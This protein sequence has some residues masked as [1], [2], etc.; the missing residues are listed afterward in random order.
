MSTERREPA[1]DVAG[2]GFGP[3]NLS[4]AIALHETEGTSAR[5]FERQAEFGWHRGMLLEDATMQVSFLKDLV[6]MRD[7]ASDFS[8]VSY[9]T[10]RGRLADFINRK[11]L[12]PL[13][14]EFH[15]YLSWAAA[16]V[17]DLVS[18]G[19]EVVDVRPVEEDGEVHAFDVVARE[20][21]GG[22]TVTRA[23]TV[24][25]GCGL[26]P[27][28]PAGV[29]CSARI[30]H[31]SE[32]LGRVDELAGSDRTPERFVV[33]GAGQSAAEAVDHLYRRFPDAEVCSVFSRFGYSPADDSPFANRVF[34]PEAVDEFHRAP[35]S[36]KRDILDYH[37]NTN[38]SVVDGDLIESLYAA[39]YQE[40]VEGR[41]RLRIMNV[42]RVTEQVE[43]EDG[44]RLHVESST[45]LETEVLDCDAVVYATGYRPTDPVALLGS[46]GGLVALEDDLP[47]VER[48]H[49]LR[50]RVPTAG[51]R[52]FL[53][54][55]DEHAFGL[56]STLLSTVA[57]R[58]GE[59]AGAITGAKGPV[60][61][62]VGD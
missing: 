7:P 20:P 44:V 60:A 62:G 33:V 29:A 53:Q 40:L 36:A 8:F 32:L 59:I 45:T 28:V 35:E 47:V 12:F 55:A 54:G 31:T 5:F 48:D 11:T 23:T 30:W 50:L 1:V 37:R 18:Y 56:T 21:D 19:S 61:A 22:T 25:V 26:T 49:G 16:R 58:A 39:H 2:I 15:D 3:S 52:L 14:I 51:A 38:Y 9:L 57:V 13:R 34:D 43:G 41:E 10:D 4:L 24:V 27:V 6:T 17:D 42:S 46:A